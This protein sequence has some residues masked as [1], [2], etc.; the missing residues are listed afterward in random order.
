MDLLEAN[1][2]AM[3]DCMRSHPGVVWRGHAKTHKCI[4]LARRQ[5]AA[6]AVGICVQKT[7]EAEVFAEAGIEDILVTNQIVDPRKLRRLAGL[8]RKSRIAI[9]CDDPGNVEAIAAAAAAE[10]TQIDVLVE[11]ETGAQ[12][13]G[14][15]GKADLIAVVTAIEA[16]SHLRFRGLQAY[17]GPAQHKRTAV[18]RRAA[19]D[20]ASRCVREAL[21]TLQEIGVACETVTGGGTGTFPLEAA[22]GLYT[23]VQPGS[24]IFMDADY[25][26]NQETE[27]T[28][29][30]AF[31]Q[32][33]FVLTS[34]T[35]L[36]RGRY[37]LVDAGHKAAAVDSG[38]PVVFGQSGMTYARAADDYG[39]VELSD[40][41]P[42]IAL[43]M[44]IKLIPGHC[45]PTVNLH[46][47][48]VG[49]RD[50]LVECV[51]PIDARGALL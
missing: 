34:V 26:R 50:D 22:S 29:F 11:I 4:E 12:R 5:I 35:S 32:S 14:V 7:G 33:L 17:N 2:R 44:T 46:N 27:D 23:E 36:R 40:E 18:E 28:V 24:F 21:L 51:W 15:A 31:R 39:L 1:L 25:T 8:A 37:L 20:H 13:A 3:T 19:I 6:G 45:D 47:W 10:K 43:G 38:M 49:V 9:C 41:A 48:I 42:E 30:A 16:A